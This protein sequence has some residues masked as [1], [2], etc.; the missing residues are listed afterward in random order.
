MYAGVHKFE[1]Y[2]FTCR[3]V[4]TTKTSTDSYRGAGRPEAAY[5]VER[6]MDSITLRERN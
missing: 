1:A 2:D 5:A 3:G 4:F 6:I